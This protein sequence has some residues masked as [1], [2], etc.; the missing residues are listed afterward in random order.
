[1]IRYRKLDANGD[2]IFGHGRSDYLIDSAPAVAQAVVTRLKLFQGEWF[3]DVTF[4]TPWMTQV[5][6]TNTQ[7]LYDTAIKVVVLGV[8]GVSTI[9][10][11]SSSLN[12]ATRALTI[13]MSI[14]TIFGAAVVNLTTT[15]PAGYGVGG[16]GLGLYGA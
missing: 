7:S 9:D 13:Q 10:S 1:M 6:G 11:Y 15:V 14:T 16:F 2:M 4:G 12:P 3:L 8:L 5:V